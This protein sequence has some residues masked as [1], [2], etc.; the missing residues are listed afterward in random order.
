MYA[1]MIREITTEKC[2]HVDAKV[3]SGEYLP[4]GDR[5]SIWYWICPDCGTTGSD[6]LSSSFKPIADTARYWELMQKHH[7]GAWVPALHRR[8]YHGL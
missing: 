4:R 5:V 8:R 1:E 7:P 6:D 3:Y 2:A